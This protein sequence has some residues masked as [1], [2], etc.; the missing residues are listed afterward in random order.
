MVRQHELDTQSLAAWKALDITS[1]ATEAGDC[2]MVDLHAEEGP[3]E[4]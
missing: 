1:N 2:S 4:Y 3:G